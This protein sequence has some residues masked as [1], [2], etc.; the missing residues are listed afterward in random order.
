M[1]MVLCLSLCACGK[2]EVQNISVDGVESTAKDFVVAS[3]KDYIQSEN[4]LQ[5]QQNFREAFGSEPEALKVT[6]VIELQLAG[7]HTNSIDIHYLAVKADFQW[8]NENGDGFSD[9]LL[10]VDYDSGNVYDESMVSESWMIEEGSK[11]Y[12]TYIM[13]NGPLCGSGYSDGP[14]ISSEETRS[15]L[16]KADINDINT[17][18][19]Q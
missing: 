11:E 7:E 9:K 2:G 3:L 4:Y 10:V 18:I 19:Y 14:I 8:A 17:A 6:R 5:I 16:S 12:W 13:L 15:E 1:A